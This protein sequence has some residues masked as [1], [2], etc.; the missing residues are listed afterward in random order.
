MA[1]FSAV[2][3]VYIFWT[4]LAFRNGTCRMAQ[5]AVSTSPLYARLPR[6]TFNRDFLWTQFPSFLADVLL[7][8]VSWYIQVSGSLSCCKLALSIW[9]LVLFCGLG[10]SF[11][12]V[13]RLVDLPTL[14]DASE[15]KL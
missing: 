2:T 13:Y 14:I 12:S 5:G 9:P 10:G 3:G 4:T 1:G 8:P 6:Q 7:L 15:M 11:L